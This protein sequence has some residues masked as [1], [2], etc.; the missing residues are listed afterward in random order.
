MPSG[1]SLVVHP[2]AHFGEPVVEGPENR[3]KNSSHDDVVKMRNYKI[4]GAELPV[5]RS[6]GKHDS[7]QTCDQ[8]LEQECD[9]K[10]H[11]R[12]ELNLA[13][14]HRANPIE[15]F[16]SGGN[17]DDHRG[18]REETVSIRTHPDGEHVVG[19]DARAY[20]TDSNCSRNH[21]WISKDRL[22]RENRNDFRSKRE[23]RDNQ[24][25]NFGMSENP[26]EV[27]P[28]DCGTSRLRVKE[29]PAE[30]TIDR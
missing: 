15:D 14:P 23:A 2:A 9:A 26:E 1:K 25:V 7:R 27:H 8:E 10:K 16:D 30:I 17:T 28:Q 20:E 3:K 21:H 19:P 29:V 18:D 24:D 12:L 4:G 22:A 5:E 13:A 11:G 6:C